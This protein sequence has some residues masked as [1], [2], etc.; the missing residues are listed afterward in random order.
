MTSIQ[1]V[2]VTGAI[3]PTDTGDTFP[4]ID[5]VYGVDGWRATADHTTRNAI[6]TQRRR[7]GMIVYTLNDHTAWQLQ[8]SPW[9]GTDTDWATLSANVGTG[10]GI[11]YQGTWNASTNTPTIVSGTGT[12]GQYFLVSVSGTTLIDGI[13]T[14]NVG[15]WIVFNGTVWERVLGATPNNS[16]TNAILAQMPADTL[17]GNNTGSTANASDLTVA[18]VTTLLEGT[19]ANTLTVGNDSRLSDART[20]TGAA[21]GAL[22]GTYPNPG[23][24]SG[25]VTNA[26]LAGG[27]TDANLATPYIKADG[28]RSFTGPESMG[29]N[30]LRNVATP[31]VATD[32]A[33][34]AYVDAVAAG[35]TPKLEVN[36]A[37]TAALAAGTYNNG[38]AGVGATF[39]ITATGVLTIDGVSIVLNNR[40]MLKNQAAA[41]QNGVYRCT[42]AGA[43]GVSAVLTRDTDSDS[44]AALVDAVYSILSGTTNASLLWACSNTTAPIIG[45]DVINFV[46]FLPVAQG[47]ISGLIAGAG[48][49]KAGSTISAHT[50]GVTLSTGGAG[51]SLEVIPGVFTRKDG[52]I[53]FTGSQ[54]LGGN[55]IT[56]LANGTVSTDAAAFGQIPT[57]L[58]PNGAAGGD[59][60]GT[61]PNPTLALAGPGATGPVGDGTH[62]AAVTIDAKGRVTGLSPVV[63]TGAAPTGVAGGDLTGNFP[64]PAIAGNVVTNAKAAQMPATT[65]K[66]NNTGALANASDLTVAQVATLLAGTSSSTLTI[67]NDAR[68][69]DAR[70]PTGAAGGDLTGTYPNPTLIATG[71]GATGPIGDGTHVPVVTIDA[72]GRVTGLT[73]SAISGGP[74]TGAAGGDLTGTYPNPTVAALAITDAKVA[75][76]NKDGTAITPS[77]RTLGTGA[78]QATAGNDSRLS[79]ARTPTGAASGDLTGT[80]PSPTLVN[81]GPGATGPVGDSS[82]VAAV[83]I[84]A[85]GRVTGLTPVAITGTAPTGAA[86]GDLTGTYPNPT[87]TTAGPGATG[88]I[89]DATHVPIVTIDAKGRVTG[90][91]SAAISGGPPSGAAGG[92]LTGTYPNPTVA[93]LAIT[94]AK[95]AAANKDGLATV[96]SMRTLG[97]GALQATA[98]N[99]ARLSDA[100]T[101]TGAAGG[102]LTG[103]YPNPGIATVPVGSGGTG[104]TALNNGGILY[105][106]S[107][108]TMLSSGNTTWNEATNL[109]SMLG[110][111][112]VGLSSQILMKGNANGCISIAQNNTDNAGI[113]FD[114]EW[115]QN[116]LRA[117]HTN[118]ALIY[119]GS[120]RLRFYGDTGL[121]VGNIYTP[122]QQAYMDCATG[123][124]VFTPIAG[125]AGVIVANVTRAS[126]TGNIQGAIISDTGVLY[127]NTGSAW[128]P[129]SAG[130]PPGGAAGGSLTGTYPNPTIAASAVTD[131]NLAVSYIKADGTRAFTGA[132]SHG[133]NKITNLAD[134]TALTDAATINNLQTLAAGFAVT[135]AVAATTGALPANTYVNGAAGI[136]ATITFT[137]AAVFTPDG[138]SPAAGDSYLVKDEAGA[139]QPHN[140]LYSITQVGTSILPTILTRLFEMDQSSEFGGSLVTIEHGT[141]NGPGGTGGANQFLCTTANPTIGTTNITFSPFTPQLAQIAADTILGN[142][143]GSSAVP[144]GLTVAQASAL[145]A[146]TTS[147][148]L[149]IGNDSRLSDARTPVGSAGGDLTGTYPNPTLAAI[150]S[151]SGPIGDSTHVAAVTIDTKG[152]V[153][154]LSAVAITGGSPTGAAGGDLA[155][156]YPNPTVSQ[157][158]GEFALTGID[159]PIAIVGNQNNYNP[160]GLSAASILRLSASAPVNITGLAGGAAGRL[161]ILENVGTANITLTNQGG[162]STAANRFLFG[163]DLV[164]APNRNAALLYDSTQNRWLCYGSLLLVGT[165]VEAWSA[166]LDALASVMSS[167]ATAAAQR[168]A[169]GLGTAA[170]LNTGTTHGQVAIQGL[171]ITEQTGAAYT[172]VAADANTR[173]RGNRATAQIFT[174]DT[175]ANQAFSQ[176]DTI[177]IVQKGVGQITIAASGGVTINSAGGKLATALQWVSIF[178]VN[179]DGADTWT[180][181]GSLG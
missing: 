68:L 127:Y 118:S 83:T 160:G 95:T 108:S 143:T 107:T 11:V 62:V 157:A 96:P 140:G 37:T 32:A 174:V 117:R 56:S 133:G 151:A 59:L 82:H 161:L 178:L 128:V 38:T 122:T 4:V 41:L 47:G 84:D 53:P 78:L 48:I 156:T 6:P 1:G 141:V 93:A 149:C 172:F 155:G 91:T 30:L 177:E 144:V 69:S 129:L 43:V 166:T 35:L 134:G 125:G 64:N 131:A 79:D 17:K 99:D 106:G 15:D 138:Y 22:S 176:G 123:N 77:M 24:A 139:N 51:S 120:G 86:G 162:S 71:P 136:G 70:T 89:G 181:H 52:T 61:Y 66:G 87:L 98:G 116:V 46:Q 115:S 121:T 81:S 142:N 5:P 145:L 39:T 168:T 7:E 85:K 80:Y 58:P 103:T 3:V 57:A 104:L 101:P 67:G 21:G 90:L 180:L 170:V 10:G 159:S 19:T 175:H 148:T 100:R 109:L 111:N 112:N 63:I 45:T 65:L 25:A 147:T 73:S 16:V 26:M 55:K 29:G 18:Q 158:S 40:V 97:V 163:A 167:T 23:I 119:K 152:R 113:G 49:T 14:W 150:G 9:T 8:P 92:D 34:A 42:I 60:N 105:A 54:S 124:W 164:I 179:E 36:A 169:L 173:I 94:D 20:P 132:Q 171:T 74:P 76:A 137:T 50:D 135:R 154:A 130:V 75:A 33:N 126:V 153:I 146:G 165:D 102:A 12:N 31:Q 2:V 88:P 27:I 110:A 114:A 44:G 72:K 13:S 28:T